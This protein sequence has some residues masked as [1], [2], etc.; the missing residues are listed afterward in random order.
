M[1]P[2]RELGAESGRQLGAL[3]RLGRDAVARPTAVELDRGLNGLLA[4]IAARDERRERRVRRALLAVAAVA[5]LILG[6][7][8]GA[9]LRERWH[10]SDAPALAYRVEGGH[11]LEGGYLRS[12]GNGEVKVSFSEGTQVVLMPGARGRLRAVDQQ[13][14]RVVLDHGTASFE[15]ARSKNLH[16][17]VEAGPFLVAVKGT[18]FTVSWDPVSEQFEL[19]L[20]H[21]QVVVSG[22]VLEGNIELSAGRRLVVN[23]PRAETRI[24]EEKEVA[25]E[26]S[27]PDPAVGAAAPEAPSSSAPT[28]VSKKPNPGPAPAVSGA[29]PARSGWSEQLARGQ[30]DR[31]LE[32]AE[33][34]GIEATLEKASSNEL[35]ALADAARYRGRVDVARAALLA[36]RRRFPQGPRS[37]DAL[38][39]LGRVTEA[40]DRSR[41]IEWYD[42]YLSR[43]ATGTYAAEALGRKM[44]LIK[45]LR[46]RAA[47]TPIAEEYLRRFPGGSYAGSARALCTP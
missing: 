17:F 20:R 14:S 2:R 27:A 23:L 47:A 21:G 4:R 35:F 39:L 36:Q 18:R 1:K 22:P 10:T 8:L 16:W 41:A 33:R 5:C 38:F 44:I 30:W 32:D 42:D 12:S 43:A 40:Q 15:V 37:L 25:P 13:G 26:N 3:T 34:A 6:V 11:V 29:K 45:E 19:N 7:R 24:S 46:G 28:S 9:S 31:I